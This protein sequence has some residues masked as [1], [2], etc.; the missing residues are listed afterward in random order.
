MHLTAYEWERENT[1]SSS[2]ENKY[3]KA[4]IIKIKCKIIKR[5]F[6]RERIEK[7]DQKGEKKKYLP[8]N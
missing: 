5:S 8:K 2:H 6:G 1:Q 4:K 7:N 3:A